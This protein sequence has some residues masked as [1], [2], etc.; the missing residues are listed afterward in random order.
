MNKGIIEVTG[1]IMLTMSKEEYN[2]CFKDIKILDAEHSMF[3]DRLTY[4]CMS[5]LFRKT[6]KGE[7]VPKYNI[8]YNREKKKRELREIVE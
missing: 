8:F 4:R 6:N 5:D 2:V 7:R 3:D 1:H